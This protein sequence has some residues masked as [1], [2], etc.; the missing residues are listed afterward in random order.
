[1]RTVI[2]LFFT[3]IIFTTEAYGGWK[4]L[5]PG[6]DLGT[7]PIKQLSP[8][9][10]VQITV[11]RLD[12]KHWELVLT[13]KSWDSKSENQTAKEWCEKYKLTA[14]INA[15]MFGTDYTTHV[16]YLATKEHVN[17]GHVNKYLSV[18]AFAPKKRGGLPQFR[19]F[20]LDA[21]GV[22]MDTILGDFYSVV[23]NLRLIKR[24]GVSRWSR[25]DR[26]WSEAALGED[27]SGRILFMFSSWP[28]SMADFNRELLSAGIDLVA[29]QHLEG[30]PKAQFYLRI[31]DMSY[32]M[33]GSY[34]T[35]SRGDDTIVNPW[36]I[37]N[38]LGV[39]PRP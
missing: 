28:L 17:N 10:D 15:G 34:E 11:L 25:Q 36:P 12:P 3:I 6:M 29:A 9:D 2:L 38:I 1:M 37:P 39:R 7:F 13:G 22:T 35:T 19:I 21:P 5:A 27:S 8:D 32:E 16:G 18:A 4:P 23:Q 31:G 20:D 14:A 26:K 24:P 30:G 33:F